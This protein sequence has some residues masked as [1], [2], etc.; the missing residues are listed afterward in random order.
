M[1]LKPLAPE[2]TLAD[3]MQAR[4]PAVPEEH[5]LLASMASLKGSHEKLDKMTAEIR[6][7]LFG[8]LPCRVMACRHERFT[9]GA[10]DIIRQCSHVCGGW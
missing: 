7:L 6:D 9:A 8:D 10:V 4:T 2:Q 1:L 3:T 5:A